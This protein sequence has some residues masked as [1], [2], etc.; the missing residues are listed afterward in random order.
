MAPH[1]YG[2]PTLLFAASNAAAVRPDA[3]ASFPSSPCSLASWVRSLARLARSSLAARSAR[4][5]A[6][7]VLRSRCAS[8]SLPWI[9]FFL[10]PSSLR[11]SWRLSS[12]SAA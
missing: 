8:A 3:L 10:L 5:S 11:V 4:S 12:F 2:I 9:S 1:T 7:R 6:V